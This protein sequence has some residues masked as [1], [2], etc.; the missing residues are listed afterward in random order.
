[1]KEEESIGLGDTIS[2]ITKVTGIKKFVDI[3]PWE[4]GCS[5]RKDALN[6]KFPY[7]K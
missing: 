1:M 2:K 7:K 5:K 6:K 4:C 3:L